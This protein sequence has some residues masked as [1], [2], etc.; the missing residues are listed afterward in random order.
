MSTS[1]SLVYVLYYVLITSAASASA[2]A[3][4]HLF[5]L[6]IS[7]IDTN[8]QRSSRTPFSSPLALDRMRGL[9]IH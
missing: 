7:P 9:E 5:F 2:S 8:L 1:S 3:S 4:R 6:H